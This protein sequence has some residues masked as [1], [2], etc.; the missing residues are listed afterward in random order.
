MENK[1]ELSRSTRLARRSAKD[2]HAP[3][4]WFEEIRD[5]AEERGLPT[6]RWPDNGCKLA[7]PDIDGYVLKGDDLTL[8]CGKADSGVRDFNRH[9]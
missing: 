3:R 9:I 4:D 2:S 6:A 8:V 5:Q 1:P 7:N